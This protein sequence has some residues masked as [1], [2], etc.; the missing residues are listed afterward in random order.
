MIRDNLFLNIAKKRTNLICFSVLFPLLA[1][2][3]VANV[4]SRCA[5]AVGGGRGGV[6]EGGRVG[7]GGGVGAQS[8][9]L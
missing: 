8:R 6:G 4:R 5:I 1:T 2:S 3:S 7:E 9:A